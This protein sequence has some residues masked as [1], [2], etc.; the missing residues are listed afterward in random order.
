MS[1]GIMSGGA[2]AGPPPP[3]PTEPTLWA[4]IPVS[5]TD[6]GVTGLQV[7]LRTGARIAGRIAFEGTH[8]PPGPDQLQRGSIDIISAGGSTSFQISG[9]A[10]RIETDGRFSSVGYPPG[11]YIVSASVPSTPS[12]AGVAG[13]MTNWTLKSA[14]LGGHDVSDEGLDVGG[15]DVAGLVITFTDRQTELMGTVRDAKG[16][17]DASASVI[18][19]P[20]D[21]QAWRQGVMN[22]R[23]LRN[24]RTTTT[25]AFTVAGLP[26]GEYLVAAVKEDTIVEWQDPKFLEKVAAIAVRVTIADGEKKSQEL[27]TKTIR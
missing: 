9:A 22:V 3:L 27:A 8:D 24:V 20:G 13:S 18:I 4:T 2:N 19:L 5:V 16:Q 7:S 25:G 12:A 1:M 23:R 15:E 14:T 10:K 6:T 21:S 26:S 17:P 11:R